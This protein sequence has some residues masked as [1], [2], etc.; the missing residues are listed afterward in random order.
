MINI[1]TADMANF[2]K[3]QINLVN[4]HPKGRRFT[5][6]DKI[7]GL[8]LQKQSAKSYKTFSKMFTMPSRKTLSTPLARIPIGP[9]IHSIIFEN[10]KLYADK[11]QSTDKLCVLLFDEMSLQP[12]LICNRYSK[13]FEGF[14]DLGNRR[15]NII[16]DHGQVFMLKGVDKHWKQ[17]IAY[18]FCKSSTKT[19][20][21][22]KNLKNIVIECFNAGLHIVSSY[23]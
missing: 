15:T 5:L 19:I 4:V 21:L 1:V 2:I 14:E 18:N 13:E 20:D 22:V 12:Y 23:N 7:M 8:V 11:L 16:A 17:P 10:L 9:G 3:S 6:D